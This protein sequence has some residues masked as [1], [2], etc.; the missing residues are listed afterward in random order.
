MS[1]CS[2]CMFIYTCTCNLYAYFIISNISLNMKLSCARCCKGMH[3]LPT[4]HIAKS[5]GKCSPASSPSKI[6]TTSQDIRTF[7]I[8]DV[9]HYA[10]P[11]CSILHCALQA[12]D[13]YSTKSDM[14][15]QLCN[16]VCQAQLAT[17]GVSEEH[18]RN[19]HA[20]T[21]NKHMCSQ[22]PTPESHAAPC[23][24]NT[25]A[26][27]NRMSTSRPAMSGRGCHVSMQHRQETKHTCWVHAT[28][29]QP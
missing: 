3:S 1:S 19:L 6:S 12:P 21:A 29:Q 8:E 11:G 14:P 22:F 9:L 27:L 25:H 18:A 23:A 2:T 15:S 13:S 7:Y 5:C 26:S 28:L 17:A 4:G 24:P 10:A 16:Y 20:H